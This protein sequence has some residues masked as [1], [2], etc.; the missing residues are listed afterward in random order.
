MIKRHVAI[1]WCGVAL[2]GCGA[3]PERLSLPKAAERV[4]P[5]TTIDQRLGSLQS[6]RLGAGECG[7]FLWSRAEDRPLI[8]FSNT[9]TGD[10]RVMVDGRQQEI[11]RV[12]GTGEAVAGQQ[13]NQSFLWRDLRFN[14]A[15]DFER[16]RELTRGAV[17]QRGTL[18]L[19]HRDGWEYVVPVGGLVACED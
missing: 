16:R 2:A 17:I 9:K 6:Q 12:S 4:N 19:Q 11:L 13:P 7:M 5:P 3:M 10:A 15:V 18:Q 14:V 1:L 8:F